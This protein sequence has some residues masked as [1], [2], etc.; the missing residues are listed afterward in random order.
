VG[1]GATQTGTGGA[2]L[3]A[4]HQ[5]SARGGTEGPDSGVA[6]WNAGQRYLDRLQTVRISV[7]D[8]KRHAARPACETRTTLPIRFT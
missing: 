7:C 2:H 4:G 3:Y 6:R 5:E 1:A 8:R